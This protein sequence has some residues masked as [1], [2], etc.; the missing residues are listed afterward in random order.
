MLA[1]F[2]DALQVL[3]FAQMIPVAVRFTIIMMANSSAAECG[4]ITR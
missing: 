1:R 2:G 3:P 4:E